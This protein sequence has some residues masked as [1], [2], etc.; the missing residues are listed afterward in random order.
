MPQE[1]RTD[2]GDNFLCDF[3]LAQTDL[4]PLHKLEILLSYEDTVE[5]YVALKST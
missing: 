4:L 2:T 1:H 3:T 5:L